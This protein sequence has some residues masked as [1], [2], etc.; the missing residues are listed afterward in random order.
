MISHI[1][2]SRTGVVSL[3]IVVGLAATTYLHAGKDKEKPTPGRLLTGKVLD[4]HDNPLVDSVVY[5]S[6]TRTHAVTTYIVGP[7]GTYRFPELPP[8]VEFEVYAQYKGQKSDTKT[9]SQFD[10]RK[11]VN[12]VLRIDVK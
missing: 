11:Q 5:L 3:L 1:G 8:N 4:K 6:N 12:I 7:D 10:D 9:L 2:R